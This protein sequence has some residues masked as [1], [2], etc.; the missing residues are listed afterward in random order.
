MDT[1]DVLVLVWVVTS[2]LLGARRGLTANLLS[3]AGFFAGAV[4]GSRVAPH[5]LSGGNQSP[6]VPAAGLVG[7]MAGGFIVQALAGTAGGALRRRVLVGPLRTLDTAGGAVAG[8]VFGLALTWLAAT[9]ALEQPALGLRADVRASSLL[10]ALLREVPPTSVLDLLSS[11]DP[12]PIIPAI[13]DRMLPPPDPAVLH[14]PGA[15][16][17]RSRVV[18]VEGTACGTGIQGSGWVVAPDVVATNAHVIAGET[19]TEV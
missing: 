11:V 17:A 7:A 1:V 15:V 8:V 5:L 14:S 12:L 10:P 9:V 2:A 3:L 13:A 16:S 19:V 6:W 18:K 4:I